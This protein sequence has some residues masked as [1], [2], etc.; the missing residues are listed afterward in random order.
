MAGGGA[1]TPTQLAIENPDITL[2]SALQMCSSV[3]VVP[4]PPIQ[5]TTGGAVWSYWKTIH[6]KVVP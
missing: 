6:V 2:Q 5:P 1:G 4:Y 3:P